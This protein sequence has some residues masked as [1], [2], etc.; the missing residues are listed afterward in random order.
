[1]S[2][3]PDFGVRAGSE[4]RLQA[5]L[6]RDPVKIRLKAELRTSHSVR[7]VDC[8]YLLEKVTT[9]D[10]IIKLDGFAA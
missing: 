8:L 9:V 7:R 4:F 3:R 1:V 6:R 10:E 2:G 5:E